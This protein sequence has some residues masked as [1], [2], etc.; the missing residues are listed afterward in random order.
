M[1]GR[2]QDSQSGVQ[3]QLTHLHVRQAL[4]R[5]VP[6]RPAIQ[7]EVNPVLGTD[8][9]DILPRIGQDLPAHLLGVLEGQSYVYSGYLLAD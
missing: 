6:G 3:L 4:P 7:T 9:E 8:I 5:T 1:R 2:G